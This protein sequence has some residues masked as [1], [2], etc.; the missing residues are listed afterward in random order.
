MHAALFRLECWLWYLS[1][2]LGTLGQIEHICHFEEDPSDE[3]V[4]RHISQITVGSVSAWT[5]LQELACCSR[6]GWY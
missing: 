5:K 3:A 4:G 6:S 2:P 1:I